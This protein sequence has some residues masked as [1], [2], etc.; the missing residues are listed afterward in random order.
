MAKRMQKISPFLWLD[1][2]AEEAVD[3]YTSIFEDSRV[4]IVTRYGEAGA[5]PKG[6][7]M[8]I[9][10]ELAGQ[11][12]VALNGGP[13]FQFTEAISF[14]GLCW[15]ILPTI[16]FEFLQSNDTQASQRVMK[17]LFQMKKLDIAALEQAY[18]GK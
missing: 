16:L 3:F 18:R 6:S 10:F 14:V 1:H 13:Q 17:A 2:Q 7:V 8:T 15:Q 12:F 11:E 9:A 5:G 4:T